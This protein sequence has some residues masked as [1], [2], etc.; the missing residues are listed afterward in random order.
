MNVEEPM[1]RYYAER[2]AEYERIY[3]KPERQDDL[4]E[5]R[6]FVHQSF[7]Q[8]G[9]RAGAAEGERERLNLGANFRVGT[10]G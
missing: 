3:Q 10:R 7:L 8:G 9:H 1:V 4:R 6:G 5:L 2:A